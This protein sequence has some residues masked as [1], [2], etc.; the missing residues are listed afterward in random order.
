MVLAHVG[1]WYA[2]LMYV[3]PLVLVVGWLKFT[4][5]REKRRERSASQTD[6]THEAEP[7]AGPVRKSG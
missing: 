2:E 3:A 7:S 5:A 6:L 4:G 1:H